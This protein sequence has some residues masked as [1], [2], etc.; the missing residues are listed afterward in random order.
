MLGCF[1]FW[2]FLCFFVWFFFLRKLILGQLQGLRQ[3]QILL[4]RGILPRIWFN[5]F[6]NLKIAS[7]FLLA[8]FFP[9]QQAQSFDPVFPTEL[10]TSVSLSAGICNSLIHTINRQTRIPPNP[11]LRRADLDLLYH[12]TCRVMSTPMKYAD[13]MHLLL[14]HSKVKVRILGYSS[15][16][17]LAT[18]CLTNLS[19]GSQG[20][21]SSS[22]S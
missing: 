2:L 13:N 7:L 21:V 6:G 16:A 5:I 4:T 3:L 20:I 19:L 14:P 11:M 17:K 10:E 22:N 8:L 15:L 18:L 9:T 12:L 1:G